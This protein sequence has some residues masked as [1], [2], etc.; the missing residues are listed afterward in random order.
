LEAFLNLRDGACITDARARLFVLRGI[1]MQE[2]A[3]EPN[4]DVPFFGARAFARRIVAETDE[5]RS[6]L[7]DAD[8]ERR[9]LI[10]KSAELG[11]ANEQLRAERDLARQQLED[12]GAASIL[13]IDARRQELQQRVD[14]LN[15]EVKNVQAS[16]AAERDDMRKEVATAQPDYRRN[17][18]DSPTSRGWHLRLSAS[19][20]RCSCIREGS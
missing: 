18:R 9:A 6:K 10:S 11:A 8:A 1:V 7:D 20:H 5:L 16:I 4:R 13:D 15:Q 2:I 17:K 3:Y 14:E 12:F 19:A